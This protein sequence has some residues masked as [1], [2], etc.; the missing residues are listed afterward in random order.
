[1]TL[2]RR[3]FA[4]E[5]RA[6]ASL[7]RIGRYGDTEGVAAALI[8]TPDPDKGLL[9]LE[10]WIGTDAD[11]SSRLGALN[12]NPALCHRLAYILSAS[13]PLADS[14]AKNPELALILGDP[15]ELTRPVRSS[16]V[17]EEGR[18]LMSRSNSFLHS[19]D[20]LRYL[21]LR[22][23]LRIVSN[24]LTG[25]WEPEVV[26]EALS[27]LADAVL[28][29]AADAV[30]REIDPATP[31]PIA[32]IAMGKHGSSEVNYSSD[33]DL[34][35]V[36]GEDADPALCEKFCGRFVRALEGKMGRGALYRIDLRLRP[37]GGAGPV[38]LSLSSTIRY[39][40]SYCEPW[41]VQALVRARACA[42][43]RAVGDE[44]VRQVGAFVYKGPRSDVFLDGI[45]DAKKR[46]EAEVRIRGEAASN[47]KLGPGGIRDAE[48]IVQMYQ[49]T[50]GDE[51]PS[52]QGAGVVPAVDVL[53]DLGTLAPRTAELL[54]SSYRFYRQVEHRIQLRQ[55][56]QAHN[57]PS[58]AHERQVLAKLTG[59]GAWAGLDSEL[60]RRRAKL[61]ELLEQNIPALS[62][63]GRVEQ[64]LAEALQL[65][66]GTSAAASAEKLFASSDSPKALLAEVLEDADTAERVE[67]MVTRAPRVV[68]ELSFHRE[69]W[70]VAFGE[71]IEFHVAD[72]GEPGEDLR[73][74]LEGYENWAAGLE[75]ALRR[76]AFVAALKDAFHGDVERTFRYVSSVAEA[77]L[78][79]SL[80]KIGGGDIDVVALGRLGS[81]EPLL[82]SDWDVMLL[83]ADQDTQARAERIGQDWVRAAR[84]ISMASGY[85]PLDVRLRPEGGAGL[86]VRSIAGFAAYANSAMEAWERLALTRGRSLRGVAA[87]TEALAQAW[88]GREWTWEDEQEILQMRKRV[89]TERMRPWEAGRDL[90]LS[91]GCML[92]AEWLVA[93]LKL[94]H[95]ETA[96]R[97]PEPT[98]ACIRSLAGAGAVSVSDGETIAKATLFF[99]RLRNAMFLLDLESDSVLPE[100]PEKLARIA[101][102]VGLDSANE[103]LAEVAQ[104]RQ[105]VSNVFSEVI[106]GV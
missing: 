32:V 20:R 14:L 75:T 22:H 71:Q 85:F 45:I 99:A 48:F 92:D 64:Q 77:A 103:L 42:G 31:L 28:E 88:G 36:S 3:V 86:V 104:H 61:R 43:N 74:A 72:D 98:H 19:L 93:L 60:R 53:T 58:G 34:I 9:N 40:L 73:S 97:V 91:D 82:G 106:Q 39:Y 47:I 10:R 38:F 100:N 15:G 29:L 17:I 27:G 79:L 6:D 54:R 95:P 59:F 49:L 30:W 37:M 89:Q 16:E 8:E 69:L 11:A 84:R 25:A 76:E 46:Y 78:L 63:S 50:M 21:R 56:L 4:D 62:L 90:K 5:A 7:E 70:D 81:R 83:C 96:D 67:M 51:H 2:R 12:S 65:P 26:W 87:S 23:L 55:D 41:E 105:G 66:P 101:T 35:F 94:R 68:S 57:L 18:A 1:M 33:L 102:W 52:L 24:D 44:F 13:Q 80:D